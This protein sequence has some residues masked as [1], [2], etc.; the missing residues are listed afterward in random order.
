MAG[1]HSLKHE[2]FISASVEKV[3]TA[4]STAEGLRGWNTPHVEGTGALG[5]QWNLKYTGRP[6]FSWRIDQDDP[7]EILWTCTRGPGDAVG[8]TAA[9]SFASA[10]DGRT[11]LSVVHGGWPHDEA[12]FVKCNT[13][14][15]A[16]VH[17][18]RDYVESGAS[19]PAF[20]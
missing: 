20:S 11:R 12:N 14:W 13:I 1:A 6:E 9:F 8:T 16:L 19:D 5:T 2:I 4:L 7:E 17:H 18:L 10:P 15:G 3:R